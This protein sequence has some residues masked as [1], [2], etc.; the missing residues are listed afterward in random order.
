MKKWN[1]ITPYIGLIIIFFGVIEATTF[2]RQK[3]SQP[4]HVLPQPQEMEGFGESFEIFPSTVIRFYGV[5]DNI[6]IILETINQ[7]LLK[8]QLPALKLA[9]NQAKIFN[10]AVNF[11]LFNHLVELPPIFS[12]QWQPEMDAS[13]YLILIEATSVRI[14]AKSFQGLYYAAL[15]LKQLVQIEAKRAFLPGLIIRDWPLLKMRGISLDIS[16][17]QVPTLENFKRQIQFLS[18]CKL[19]T[20]MIYLEDMFVYL[21]HPQIGLNRGALTHEEITQ[22][23]QFA[24]QYCVEIIPILQTAGHLE[25]LLILPAYRYLAEFPGATVLKMDKI[26]SIEFVE[27][28][29][30]EIVPAF[31]SEYFHIGGDECYDAGR[32]FR[33]S[34]SNDQGRGSLLA[35]H[36]TKVCEILNRYQKKVIIYGDMLQRHPEILQKLP[37]NVIIQDWQYTPKDYYPSLDVFKTKGRDVIVSPGLSNWRLFYPDYTKAFPNIESFT[38]QGQ[39]SQAQGS[40]T[41]SWGDFGGENFNEFNW[42][43]YAYAAECCWHSQPIV[44]A[45]FNSKFFE[46]FYGVNETILDSIYSNL[47]RLAELTTL[48]DFWRYPFQVNRLSKKQQLSGITQIRTVSYKLRRQIK[49]ISA[50]VVNNRYHLHYLDFVARRAILLSQ[51]SLY[52]YEI[53]ELSRAVQAGKR[54]SQTKNIMLALAGSVIHDLKNLKIVF[55]KLWLLQNEKD[56]LERILE[57]YDRQIFYWLR[58]VEEIKRMNYVVFGDELPGK[59]IYHPESDSKGTG[60]DYAVFLK[61]FNLEE[62]VTSFQFQTIGQSHLRIYFNGDFIGDQIA[63]PSVSLIVEKERVKLWD[64]TSLVQKGENQLRIEVF[65]YDPGQIPSAHVYGEIVQNNYPPMQFYSDASWL[66]NSFLSAVNGK[67]EKVPQWIFAA[68]KKSRWFITPPDFEKKILSTIEW[69]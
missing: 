5:S 30:S 3:T 20:L 18:S 1:L 40:I 60:K 9:G 27:S 32:G 52:A 46:L 39:R 6:K 28:L 33:Q 55:E 15:T 51:Q 24:R 14:Y 57:L 37:A 10:N 66:T 11:I 44:P 58:K 53:L 16:R 12:R 42:Y 19:N 8:H 64:V 29:F 38:R 41:A 21:N 2:A 65:N 43:G 63:R 22:L 13:G 59:W 34:F 23:Q 47:S 31:Q 35:T 7:C 62:D 49:T 50:K 61:I 69:R 56:N 36:F 4:F 26:E 67:N 17:G 48:T 68:E 25:N 54:N 45:V